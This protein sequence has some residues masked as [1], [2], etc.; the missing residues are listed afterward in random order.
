MSSD[1]EIARMIRF[2]QLVPD[3]AIVTLS[4]QSSWSHV[5]ALLP[6]KDPLAREFYLRMATHN[7]WAVREVARQLDGALF[8]RAV[9]SLPKRSTALRELH[10]A[11]ASH[12]TDACLL[13]FPALPSEHSEADLHRSLLQNPGRFMTELGRDFCYVG[14]EYPVQVGGQDFALDLLYFHIASLPLLRHVELSAR[15][16]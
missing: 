3:E 15:S 1:A 7:R 2:A 11:V 6:I 8:E 13:E 9:L 10:P 14:A 4:Q 12:F 16:A 5:H